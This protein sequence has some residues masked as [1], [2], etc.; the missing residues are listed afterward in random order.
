MRKILSE[1][2]RRM[3][4]L[5]GILTEEQVYTMPNNPDIIRNLET[6]RPFSVTWDD[7]RNKPGQPYWTTFTKYSKPDPKKSEDRDVVWS[8]KHMLGRL[9]KKGVI[10]RHGDVMTEPSKYY[11]TK[12]QAY[13]LTTIPFP[14]LQEIIYSE[15]GLYD[16]PPSEYNAFG[17]RAWS[18]SIK[19]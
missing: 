5:A 10:I 14:E 18:P 9:L 15:K 12:A 2:F 3:Q 1:Q 8:L 16:T 17:N 19:K 11:G 13:I 4:Q 6:E 7:V